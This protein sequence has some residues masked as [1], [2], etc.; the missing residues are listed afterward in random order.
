MMGLVFSEFLNYVEQTMSYDMVDKIILK[1]KIPSGGAY[2]SLGDYD[3]QEFF[4]LLKALSEETGTPTPA[5]LKSFGE[6]LFVF[7]ANKHVQLAKGKKNIFQFFLELKEKVYAEIK[8][9]Y[10]DAILPEYKFDIVSADKLI[11]SY[12]SPY[13]LADLTEGLIRGCIHFYKEN[14]E[15]TREDIPVK[16]GAKAKF[17]LRKLK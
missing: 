9:F 7:L 12:Q 2:T 14:M 5:I 4:M 16:H 6:Y 3:P 8:K 15:I 13:P 11:I 10:H 17:I 1:S